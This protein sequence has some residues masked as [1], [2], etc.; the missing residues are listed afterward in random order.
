MSNEEIYNQLNSS[1]DYLEKR[2]HYWYEPLER[3]RKKLSYPALKKFSCRSPKYKL[4]CHYWLIMPDKDIRTW[5]DVMFIQYKVR[6]GTYLAFRDNGRI[7]DIFPP[8]FF[9]RLR[10]RI[11]QTEVSTEHLMDNFVCQ[12]SFMKRVA[13]DNACVV[14]DGDGDNVDERVDYMYV[15]NDIGIGLGCKVS[16]ALY[17][18][19]T[20]ISEDMLRG[21]QVEINRKAKDFILRYIELF[22]IT[23]NNTIKVRET[24]LNYVNGE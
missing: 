6:G 7:I 10:S 4:D 20:I 21:E 16:N 9:S 18:V 22:T 3:M 1:F 19:K 5:Q 23:N 12:L 8:H 24:L 11:M 17:V 15:L 14:N 2:I 13:L